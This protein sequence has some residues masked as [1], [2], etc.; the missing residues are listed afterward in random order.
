MGMSAS[1]ADDL[2]IPPPPSRPREL[3]PVTLR[4]TPR[5]RWVEL[6]IAALAGFGAAALCAACFGL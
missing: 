4:L 5:P 3:R 6:P 1:Y 2:R